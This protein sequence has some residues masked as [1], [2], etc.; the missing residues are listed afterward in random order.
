MAVD[1]LPSIASYTKEEAKTLL[2]TLREQP[3]KQQQQQ[4]K[5]QKMACNAALTAIKITNNLH[6]INCIPNM[7]LVALVLLFDFV[8]VFIVFSTQRS[9]PCLCQKKQSSEISLRKKTLKSWNGV[10]LALDCCIEHMLFFF[11][12]AHSL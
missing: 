9:A 2:H 1:T 5:Q 4:Q 8:S 3:Q 7:K 6:S 10:A 11:C 12:L